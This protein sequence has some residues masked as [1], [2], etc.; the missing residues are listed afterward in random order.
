[1]GRGLRDAATAHSAPSVRPQKEEKHRPPKIK[2]SS[3]NQ[4]LSEDDVR[5]IKAMKGKCVAREIAERFAVSR[6]AISAILSG[7]NW[8]QVN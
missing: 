1:M 3:R 2:S 4:I 5:A 7:R 6:E 8:K